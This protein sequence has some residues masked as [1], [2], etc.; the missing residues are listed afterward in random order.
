MY[1][2]AISS[3][4]EMASLDG[5]R[6]DATLMEQLVARQ[7][8]VK[9]CRCF[10]LAE[11]Y[12]ARSRYAEAQALYGRAAELMEEAA[13]LLR[14]AGYSEASSELASLA[15]LEL[16]IDG[17]KARAHAQAFVNTLT[18]GAPVAE[19][20]SKMEGMGLE[21]VLTPDGPPPLID[22]ADTFERPKPEHLVHFPPAFSTVPCK[23]LLF[24]IARGHLAPPDLSG[25][26][27]AKGMLRSGLSKAGSFFWGR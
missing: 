26:V 23:P 10:Y 21:K 19:A 8:A 9:A 27:Q 25:R 7:A 3:L 16:S 20:Q 2:A 4:Q 24:D 6:E 13:S 18:G 17:A 12:G 11:S 5:Y 22:S 1:E 14:E 15:S